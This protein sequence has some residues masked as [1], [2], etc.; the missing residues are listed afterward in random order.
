MGWYTFRPPFLPRQVAHFSSAVY[1]QDRG[2]SVTFY[3]ELT[4]PVPGMTKLRGQRITGIVDPAGNA[5]TLSYNEDGLL[6]EV[7]ASGLGGGTWTF[8]YY[9]L[10]QKRFRQIETKTDPNSNLST[11]LFLDNPPGRA[12]YEEKLNGHVILHTERSTSATGSP[13]T[14]T[15]ANGDDRIEAF[16]SA[17]N[18][19]ENITDEEGCVITHELDDYR[20]ILSENDRNGVMR[21]H[22]YDDRGN[23]LDTTVKKDGASCQYEEFE[24]TDDLLRFHRGPVLNEGQTG[25][26]L[27]LTTEYQY[28]SNRNLV[29]TIE[30]TGQAGQRRTQFVYNSVG[31]VIEEYRG[32]GVPPTNLK[33]RY[34][35]DPATGHLLQQIDDPNGENII[36]SFAYDVLGQKVKTWDGNGNVTKFAYDRF[37]RVVRVIGPCATEGELAQREAAGEYVENTYDG[38]SGVGSDLE[39]NRRAD[40]LDIAAEN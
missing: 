21:E 2:R 19:W 1:N 37:G 4:P 34:V 10:M 9:P 20:N 30:P 31:Q 25:D 35:Y 39:K 18:A 14:I 23:R 24:Y 32:T 5:T 27:A 29:L 15:N 26:L 38:K 17:M 8:A 28:D 12:H 16:S 11:Y 3:Y 36:T 6:S 22:T 13:T 40:Q 33:R 7:Q